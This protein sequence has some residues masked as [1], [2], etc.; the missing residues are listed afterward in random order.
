[1]TNPEHPQPKPDTPETTPWGTTRKDTPSADEARSEDDVITNALAQAEA[2]GDE[3]PE[4][5]ARAIAESLAAQSDEPTPAL[6]DF[7]TGGDGDPEAISVEVMPFYNRPDCP[8]GLKRQIDYLLTFVL[9]QPR[10]PDIRGAQPEPDAHEWPPAIQESIAFYGDAFR[11][12]LTLP[13]IHP[14]DPGIL[15]TFHEC[16][17]GRF[18]TMDDVLDSLT[19]R[20][21]WQVAVDQLAD[22]LGVPGYIVLDQELIADHTRETWD[23]VRYGGALY[24]FDK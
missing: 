10:H 16:Y 6:D 21:Y 20:R 17:V 5:D 4:W 2:S 18:F 11:A 3:V 1:M 14:N 23:I 8:P 19:E 22:R 15:D 7:S 13:D 24:V 12:F 9:N